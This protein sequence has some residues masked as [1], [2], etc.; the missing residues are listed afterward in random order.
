MSDTAICGFST[1]CSLLFYFPLST[2]HSSTLDRVAG[3]GVVGDFQPDRV[4][5]SQ[6]DQH[7]A[8]TLF[9]E[10]AVGHRLG[11]SGGRLAVLRGR[12]VR[13]GIAVVGVERQVDRPGD[14]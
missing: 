5:G 7:A 3:C 6:R 12:L 8:E 13:A 1:H 4:T 9:V 10:L 2:F 11:E 14:R